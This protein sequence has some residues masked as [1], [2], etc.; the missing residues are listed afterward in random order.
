MMVEETYDNGKKE[1]Q[2]I[3]K[4]MCTGRSDEERLK[5]LKNFTRCEELSNSWLREICIILDDSLNRGN[6][7]EEVYTVVEDGGNRFIMRDVGMQTDE[8]KLV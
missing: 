4:E 1:Q 3:A 8:T 7:G 2:E 6:Q 5:E